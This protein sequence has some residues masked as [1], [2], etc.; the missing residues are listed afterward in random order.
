MQKILHLAH[1][2]PVAVGSQRYVFVHP[3]DPDLIVKVPTERY[4][5]R[6]SGERGKWWKKLHRK[7]LRS[8]HFLVFHRELHEQFA[9]RASA[10]ALPP[11]VQTIVGIVETDLGMGLVSQAV[12]GRDNELAPSLLQLLQQDRFGEPARRQLDEFVRWLLE[13]NVVVGDLNPG[14]LV[15]GHDP[16]LGDHFVVIDGLGDKNLVP[17]NSFS[18]RLNRRSKLRRIERIN[19]IIAKYATRDSGEAVPASEAGGAGL[20]NAADRLR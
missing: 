5:D 12:R 11:Y 7:Y 8:R 9:L 15:F 2:K 16:V 3:H 14:N 13:S 1:L 18:A 4:V 20:A 17:L 6:R 19:A 10:A